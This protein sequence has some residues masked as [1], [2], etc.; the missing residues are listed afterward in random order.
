MTLTFT[1]LVS[2]GA[3]NET[4]PGFNTGGVH[5]RVASVSFLTARG[6]CTLRASVDAEAFTVGMGEGG[7]L[8]V[9][10]TLGSVDATGVGAVTAPGASKVEAEGSGASGSGS[11]DRTA[12]G[13]TT[14]AGL[15][16]ITGEATGVNTFATAP[17]ASCCALKFCCVFALTLANEI[18]IPSRGIAIAVPTAPKIIWGCFARASELMHPLTQE[19]PHRLQALTPSIAHHIVRPAKRLSLGKS[20]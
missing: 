6:A 10:S 4:V 7:A 11:G 12:F 17:V 2:W 14:S 1:P 5:D 16:V 3:R 19:I 8:R 15:F 9:S 20:M 13:P 18:V